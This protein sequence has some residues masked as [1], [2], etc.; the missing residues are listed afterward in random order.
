MKK[1]IHSSW[2]VQVVFLIVFIFM[3][4]HVWEAR[5]FADDYVFHTQEPNI[6]TDFVHFY[7]N[8]LKEWGLFRPAAVVW[9]WFVF[10]LYL[11][12]PGFSHMIAWG[13]HV[14][15]GYLLYVIL[16]RQGMYLDFAFLAGLLYTV[17]PFAVQQYIWLSANPGT[18]A[19]FFFLLE[20]WVIGKGYSMTRTI[21][22]ATVL[23]LLGV[24]MYESTLF[25]FI[26]IGYLLVSP[27]TKKF[28]LS[29]KQQV[30]VGVMLVA[31]LMVYI[32]NKLVFPNINPRPLNTTLPLIAEQGYEMIQNLVHTQIGTYYVENYW[33]AYSEDAI[34]SL[35]HNA[36][37]LTL[38]LLWLIGAIGF[39]LAHMK[40]SV[41]AQKQWLFWVLAF[42]FS[43]PPLLAN[44]HFTFGFRSIFLP[45]ILGF[46][47]LLWIGQ[48]VVGRT[49]RMVLNAALLYLV[50][51][52]LLV[53][54]ANIDK[55]R[56]QY[57]ED[58]EL[59]GKITSEIDYYN[60]PREGEPLAVVL[61]SDVYFDSG[62]TFIHADNFLSCFY[63]E[64]SVIPCMNMKR[65]GIDVFLVNHADGHAAVQYGYT[66]DQV[67]EITPR[68]EL[69]YTSEHE[70]YL[71]N[72]IDSQPL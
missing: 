64:W 63:Y 45:V 58:M 20:I 48:L 29:M 19:Q 13:I 57:D 36:R 28:S 5:L 56:Q 21:T 39:L 11:I 62:D 14:F 3:S 10:S 34:L 32:A 41:H 49:S 37:S 2:I 70:I 71:E 38:F 30:F 6:A 24:L 55:Y 4:T 25:L 15:C 35:T 26:P 8:Y 42:V 66:Q 17:H 18:L 52:S 51:V 69:H 46:V 47:V 59:A 72:L 50:G 40:P 61:T 60:L 31:P 23:S 27:G 12:T 68:I 54:S 7:Q 33:R 65:R 9:Y 67:Y 22:L 16:K 44:Q 1:L 43:L 53:S